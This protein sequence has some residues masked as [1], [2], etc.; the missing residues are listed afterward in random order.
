VG[1]AWPNLRGCGLYFHKG[2][3]MAWLTFSNQGWDG[4]GDGVAE[5]VVGCDIE[6]VTTHYFIK[7][8]RT[9]RDLS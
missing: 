8:V 1:R 2:L 9:M 7:V 4:V 6:A 5:M 3:F